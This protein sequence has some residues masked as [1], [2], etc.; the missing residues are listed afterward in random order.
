MGR[1]GTASGCVESPNSTD[2]ANKNG[3]FGIDCESLSTVS[4]KQGTLD[5]DTAPADLN[6][7]NCYSSIE[8]G[9]HHDDLTRGG[10][11]IIELT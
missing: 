10:K 8:I 6:N 11:A 5:G 4:G 2:I 3:V 1:P 9:R 7:D